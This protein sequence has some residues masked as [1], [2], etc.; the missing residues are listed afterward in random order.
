MLCT[1][2]EDWTKLVGVRLPLEIQKKKKICGGI[3]TRRKQPLD[4]QTEE[5]IWKISDMKFSPLPETDSVA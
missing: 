2:E 3:S 5:D 1:S 4:I